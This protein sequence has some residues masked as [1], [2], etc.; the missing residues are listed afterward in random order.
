MDVLDGCPVLDGSLRNNINFYELVVAYIGIL[1]W[2]PLSKGSRVCVS[3]DN[4]QVAGFINRGSA[5]NLTVVQWLKL[6]FYQLRTRFPRGSHTH[7]W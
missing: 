7:P 3:T 4:S 1:V 5:K 2:A 6:I